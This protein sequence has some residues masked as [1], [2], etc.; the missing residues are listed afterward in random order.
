M[1]RGRSW[2]SGWPRR[3]AR[4]LTRAKALP[5]RRAIRKS[6]DSGKYNNTRGITARV[7]APPKMNTER[8]PKCVSS[9]TDNKP[10]RVAPKA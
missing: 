6:S 2:S 7:T 5:G 10:P 4:R 1:A 8:Q 9:H 3:A